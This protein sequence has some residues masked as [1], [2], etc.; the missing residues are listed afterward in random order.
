MGSFVL[1][2]IWCSAAF[3]NQVAE[4]ALNVCPRSRGS[5]SERGNDSSNAGPAEMEKGPFSV[6]WLAQSSRGGAQPITAARRPRSP[7]AD[8]GDREHAADLG[9]SRL[10]SRTGRAAGPL[11]AAGESGRTR[12]R[13]AL[14]VTARRGKSDPAPLT[15]PSFPR[16]R[17]PGPGGRGP[18]QL[19]ARSGSRWWRRTRAA[20]HQVLGRAAAGA[21]AELPWATL[22]R[23]QR[24][25]APG[26][27]PEPLPEPG[28]RG[29]GA[30]GPPLP[31]A[32]EG[33]RATHR[34]GPRTLRKNCGGG[35]APSARVGAGRG[36]HLTITAGTGT[37]T[38]TA[39]GEVRRAAPPVSLI[40]LTEN[41][42]KQARIP[43]SAG[44]ARCPPRFCV[45]PGTVR[46]E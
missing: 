29:R 8:T 26:R 10:S 24:E 27:R 34:L 15:P 19:R 9:E 25:T 45:T 14:Y 28:E 43:A 46:G 32:G 16:S 4:G 12:D 41:Y 18:Q 1:G 44:T 22:Y 11:V 42:L 20:P 21:R 5:F 36:R 3:S 7:P 40:P 13:S 31:S 2:L 38:V 6:E 17:A 39:A 35:E 23:R 30:P 37:V 33:R